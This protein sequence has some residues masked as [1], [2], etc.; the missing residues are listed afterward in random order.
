[1][2]GETASW[3]PDERRTF[4]MAGAVAGGGL[5]LSLGHGQAAAAAAQSFAATPIAGDLEVELSQVRRA[6]PNEKLYAKPLL[7]YRRWVIP[8]R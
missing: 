3:L 2:R 1:V 7:A 6:P 4:L 5:W 8:M